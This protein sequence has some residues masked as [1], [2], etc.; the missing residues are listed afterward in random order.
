MP[1]KLRQLVVERVDLVDRGSNPGSHILLWKRDDDGDRL[2]AA[3]ARIAKA[4]AEVAR[5]NAEHADDGAD[6]PFTKVRKDAGLTQVRLALKTGLSPNYVAMIER[7]LTPSY[8]AQQALAKALGV[9]R[10]ELWPDPTDTREGARK[11]LANRDVMKS[12]RG[13]TK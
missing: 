1:K 12:D 4:Q 2:A 11:W 6:T 3:E 13:L 8:A 7:G 5:L 9:P 10:E